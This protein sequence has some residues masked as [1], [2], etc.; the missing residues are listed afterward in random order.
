MLYWEPGELSN[1]GFFSSHLY[2]DLSSGFGGK[3]APPISPHLSYTICRFEAIY[4]K[5]CSTKLL[6][7]IHLQSTLCCSMFLTWLKERCYLA[8]TMNNVN[9][10]VS[11][12]SSS[13]QE[14]RYTHSL[15]IRN[16][17]ASKVISQTN[18]MLPTLIV[19]KKKTIYNYVLL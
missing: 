14:C 11:T 9:T 1:R 13:L 10:M 8:S 3:K 19:L 4:F 16:S 15:D 18:A 12:F 5:T 2:H 7:S 6:F 17:N